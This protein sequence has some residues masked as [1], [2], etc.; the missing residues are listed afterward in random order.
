ML[1]MMQGQCVTYELMSLERGRPLA[2]PVFSLL[3]FPF[4][5]CDTAHQK[6]LDVTTTEFWK[7]NIFHSN[8][9]EKFYLGYFLVLH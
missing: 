7:T 2:I 4:Y 9:I 6:L 5:I 3:I 8:N 1:D